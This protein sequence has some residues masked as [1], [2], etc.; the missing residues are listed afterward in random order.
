MEGSANT[1]KPTQIT[2]V[3]VIL[4]VFQERHNFIIQPLNDIISLFNL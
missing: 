3:K 1:T 4:L 2:N